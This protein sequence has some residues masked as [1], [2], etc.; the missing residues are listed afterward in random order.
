MFCK[1]GFLLPTNETDLIG[2]ADL[3]IH[4]Q[5]YKCSFCGSR[6]K[7]PEIP[8]SSCRLGNEELLMKSPD[9]AHDDP[10]S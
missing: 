10:R 6:T 4:I 7:I 8:E 5:I 9:E 2:S 3:P 1:S